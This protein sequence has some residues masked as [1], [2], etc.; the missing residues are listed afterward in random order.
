MDLT[1]NLESRKQLLSLG[2]MS[3]ISVNPFTKSH[4][5]VQ[6]LDNAK[7]I[8]YTNESIKGLKEEKRSRLIGTIPGKGLHDAGLFL[9]IL[10]II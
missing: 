5:S 7:H 4:P 3:Y 6:F 1:M 2:M 8:Y 9:C 10:S